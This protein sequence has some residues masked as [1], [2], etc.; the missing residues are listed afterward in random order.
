MSDNTT[1]SAD[2][3]LNLNTICAF[4]AGPADRKYWDMT[5]YDV[6]GVLANLFINNPNASAQEAQDLLGMSPDSY[7]YLDECVGGINMTMVGYYQ[8]MAYLPQP[9]ACFMSLLLLDR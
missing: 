6:V 3:V 7:E 8:Q 1:L 4:V 9:R 2:D 5:C